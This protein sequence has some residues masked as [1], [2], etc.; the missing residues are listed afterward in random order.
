M[1][2]LPQYKSG[3]V[4]V[5]NDIMKNFK[6]PKKLIIRE[7]YITGYVLVGFVVEKDGSVSNV[8]F[9]KGLQKDL[10]KEAIRVVKLLNN[11]NPGYN[12][13]VPIRARF[14]QPIRF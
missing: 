8:K 13:G 6:Y 9:V 1:V 10:D 4:G 11:W 7:E 12:R 5:T 14:V 3:D 2:V